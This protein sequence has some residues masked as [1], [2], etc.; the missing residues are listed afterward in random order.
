MPQT[1]QPINGSCVHAD[2]LRDAGAE[3]ALSSIA[4]LSS[5]EQKRMLHQH[6]DLI[7]D[8][9]ANHFSRQSPHLAANSGHALWQRF[10]GLGAAC[11]VVAMVVIAP[12]ILSILLIAMITLVTLT[13]VAISLAP[14]R[15]QSTKRAGVHPAVPDADLPSYTILIPAYQEEDVIAGMIDSLDRLDYPRDR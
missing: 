2:P 4:S 8:H 11:A 6:S 9:M 3:G 1:A 7:A 13:H 12:S 14:A 5:D 15:Q 10:S